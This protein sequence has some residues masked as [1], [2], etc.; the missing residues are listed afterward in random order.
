MA[1]KREI[2]D[3]WK[4]LGPNFI[5]PN[6]LDVGQSRD[7]SQWWELSVGWG[8]DG[9]PLYAVTVARAG[10][11]GGDRSGEVFRVRAEAEQYA[12]SL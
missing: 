12:A 11:V 8:I 5:T 1:S 9:D 7:G 6:M 3:A 2:R 10:S 4:H